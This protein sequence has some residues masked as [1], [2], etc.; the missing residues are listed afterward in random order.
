MRQLIPLWRSTTSE[1]EREA[2]RD[3]HPPVAH[4]LGPINVP[5]YCVLPGPTAL[6]EK[7][8]PL[9]PAVGN[10]SLLIRLHMAR[11]Q[12]LLR[13]DSVARPSRVAPWGPLAAT[14]RATLGVLVVVL[15][16]VPRV[17]TDLVRLDLICLGFIGMLVASPPPFLTP[18]STSS[19]GS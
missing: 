12:M 3:V 9:A 5:N 15:K 7:E 4:Y 13:G 1:E 8:G 14:P 18:S 6:A 10:S 19:S 17:A 11:S 16:V 2:W